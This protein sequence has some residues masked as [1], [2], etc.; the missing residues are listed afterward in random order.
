MLIL[1]FIQKNMFKRESCQQYQK[2]VNKA[3]ETIA[4]LEKEME[5][6]NLKLEENPVDSNY[7]SDQRK[8]NLDMKI[9]LNE[10]EH[11][12]YILERCLSEDGDFEL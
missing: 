5:T 1:L 6:L 2:Q 8:L 9:T 12:E 3:K 7:L 10:L 4:I 11:C